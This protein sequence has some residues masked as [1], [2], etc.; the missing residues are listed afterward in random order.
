MKKSIVYKDVKLIYLMI[1]KYTGFIRFDD[2]YN[3]QYSIRDIT[4]WGNNFFDMT[5]IY[6]N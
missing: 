1:F 2:Y 3:N 4:Q 5:Y 6:L